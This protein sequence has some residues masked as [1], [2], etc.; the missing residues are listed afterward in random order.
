[1]NGHAPSLDPSCPV[2]SFDGPGD[3]TMPIASMKLLDID[4]ASI[5]TTCADCRTEIAPGLLS[6]AAAT[7]SA[8]VG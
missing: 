2:A 8:P 5:A 6:C 7:G 4:A 3:W 1:M